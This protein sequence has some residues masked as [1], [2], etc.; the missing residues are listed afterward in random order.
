MAET[1]SLPDPL[2]DHET[3]LR[4]TEAAQLA[5]KRDALEVKLAID[6]KAAKKDIELVEGKISELQ[7]QVRERQE[8]KDIEVDYFHD[9]NRGC[10]E[11]IRLDTH[12]VIHS[13]PMTVDEL[14]DARQ[15]KIPGI[16]SARRGRKYK[17]VDAIPG[18]QPEH[19]TTK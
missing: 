9:A 5:G 12:D 11:T 16:G 2:S 6:T 3:L 10:V 18:D 14:Q 8:Y 15:T 13:R 4:A 17:E 19:V 1:R 7:K